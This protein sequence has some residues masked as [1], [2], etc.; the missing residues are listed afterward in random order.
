MS[1]I[2]H[3]IRLLGEL[4]GKTIIEQAGNEL[5][6]L[7]EQ[8]RLLSKGWRAGESTAR[9]QVGALVNELVT[10]LPRTR[11]I[12][13]AFSTY[14]QLVNLAEEHERIR[15]LAERAN[16]AHL[17]DVPMDESIAEAIAVLKNE[18]FSAVD[19]EAMLNEM[20]IMPVFTA[21]PTESRRRTIRQIL[22][23][24]STSLDNLEKQPEYLHDEIREELAEYVTLLWQSD[25]N[26]KRKPTVMDEVRNTG[27]YFFENTLFEVVPKIYA[28]L[29]L[30]LGTAYPD[31]EWNLPTILRFGSWI[32]GDRDGNPFV[33]NDTTVNGLQTHRDLVLK[34]YLSDVQ[35]LYEMLSP[36]LGR[37]GFDDQLLAELESEIANL[38]A[39]ATETI[40]RFDQE[41]YRQKLILM[42]RKLDA[43]R[44]RNRVDWNLESDDFSGYRSSQEFLE[45]LQKIEKSLIDNNGRILTRGRLV[46]LIRR[47]KVFGFH[48]ATID[49]R[50][51]SGKHQAAIEEVFGAYGLVDGYSELTEAERCALLAQEINNERPLTAELRFSEAT[52]Q[53]VSLFRMVKQAHKN[54]GVE[55]IQSYVISMTESV[56]DVLEVLLLM[57][58]AGLFG[59]LDIV[60]LFETVDDL[61]AAPGIMEALFNSPVYRKHL[62]LRG[63]RQQIMIGYS[64]SNKDGGFLT[65]NW[66]LFTAQRNLARTC[67]A[68][69]IR[70]TLFHGRGGSIGRGGGPANR[71][72]LA[73]PPESVRGRFRVTEQGEVVSSRYTHDAIARRHLQ[74][75]FHAIICS[76][77]KRPEFEKLSRWSDIAEELSQ[78]ALQKYRSLVEQDEFIKYFQSATPIDQIDMLNLGSRPSKRKDSQSISDLR[79][80]PW[81]FAWTQS[82][83]NLPSWYGVGTRARRVGREGQG[84]AFGRAATDVSNL[85]ILSDVD[86]KCS[87]WC[88]ES[89]HGYRQALLETGGDA[90]CAF[91]VSKH[92]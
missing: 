31:H 39:D 86:G 25:E 47:V 35:A 8:I 44:T 83:A 1:Q 33:T 30:A 73:Q 23:H 40:R 21:H 7:E 87:R 5:F 77:G 15:I 55:S 57:S 89:G 78:L 29:K 68:N 24:I 32:G 65:A 10:D 41:P 27:L 50:Q 52:N 90:Q 18:G 11:D 62:E 36:A 37:C 66:M 43:T 26:R 91:P 48:L 82:R 12:V 92:L 74:Q 60:P 54:V 67:E 4:L 2:S 16:Q 85:A 84:G 42:Y 53:A 20:L 76:S 63:R 34:R 69:E 58:D 61:K 46:Q 70:L 6:A 17:A 80:I 72:I 9:E 88:W 71:A 81:V 45:D 38:P 49:I 64:D 3:N 22:E 19:V 56:S 59:E 28:E 13:K 51:H 79:A 14:F 75:L